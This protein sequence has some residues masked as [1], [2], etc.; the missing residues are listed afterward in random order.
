[1]NEL[2]IIKLKRFSGARSTAAWN[3]SLYGI[4]IKVSEDG[5]INIYRYGKLK[6]HIG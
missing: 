2:K 5:P 6:S 4:A 1:M 3:A